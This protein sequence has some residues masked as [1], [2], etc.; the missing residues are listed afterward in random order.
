MTYFKTHEPN[1]NEINSIFKHGKM[2]IMNLILL[3]DINML[4]CIFDYSRIYRQ[5]K[6]QIKRK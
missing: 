1:N 5:V 6:K 3:R 4:V 2:C